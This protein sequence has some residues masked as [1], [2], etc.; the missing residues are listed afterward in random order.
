MADRVG[1]FV[2]RVIKGKITTPPKFLS[3]D[4]YFFATT[5][6]ADIN[7]AKE[8]NRDKDEKRQHDKKIQSKTQKQ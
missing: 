8:D 4:G 5:T 6:V 1:R 7:D 2:V 3:L